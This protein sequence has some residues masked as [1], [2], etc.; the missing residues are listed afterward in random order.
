MK[1]ESTAEV[2]IVIKWHIED[3][4]LSKV[5]HTSSIRHIIYSVPYTIDLC[6]TPQTGRFLQT[7]WHHTSQQLINFKLEFERLPVI[8][9]H[10]ISHD[11]IRT[12][13]Q[14]GPQVM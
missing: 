5:F 12:N 3:G 7:Y 13:L 9:I 10:I 4:S 2:V 6:S 8:V 1:V 14:G 11:M